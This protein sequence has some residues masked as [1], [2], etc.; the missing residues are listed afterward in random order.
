MNDRG[1]WFQTYE[2]VPDSRKNIILPSMFPSRTSIHEG[3]TVYN[4]F[5]V[6][7]EYNVPFSR[8]FNIG[9]TNNVNCDTG[10]ISNSSYS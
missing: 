2:D 1:S 3:H 8:N 9:D 4:S 7:S 10:G 5:D 6:N